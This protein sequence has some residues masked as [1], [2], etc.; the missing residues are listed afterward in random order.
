[1]SR[2]C[3]QPPFAFQTVEQSQSMLADNYAASDRNKTRG[4]PRPGAALLQGRV[5]CGECGHRRVIEYQ[6]TPVPSAT[7]LGQPYRVPVCQDSPADAVDAQ[8]VEAFFQALSPLELEG[9][10]QAVAAQQAEEA[11]VTH[12]HEQRLSRLR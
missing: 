1:V 12:A 5:A 2:L 8:G 7:S 11:Q 6:H 4:V 3:P 9:Y 10:E